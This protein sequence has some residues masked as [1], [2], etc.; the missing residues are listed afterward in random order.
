M[1]NLKNLFLI[2]IFCANILDKLGWQFFFSKILTFICKVNM[3]GWHTRK[4]KSSNHLTIWEIDGGKSWKMSSSQRIGNEQ[5]I[6]SIFGREL[7]LGNQN[8]DVFWIDIRSIIS[9]QLFTCN[10]SYCL[11]KCNLSICYQNDRKRIKENHQTIESLLYFVKISFVGS[12]MRIVYNTNLS[13]H[14]KR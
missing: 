7:S 3:F 1:R 4:G 6:N 5:K 2:H 13:N 10:I 8:I 9:I 14:K 11:S 12:R